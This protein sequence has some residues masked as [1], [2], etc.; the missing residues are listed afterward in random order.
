MSKTILSTSFLDVS[1]ILGYKVPRTYPATITMSSQ[2][3]ERVC[4]WRGDK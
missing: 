3:P 2:E 1:A 4:V